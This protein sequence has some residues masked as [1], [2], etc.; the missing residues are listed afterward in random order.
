MYIQATI[1]H[2]LESREAAWKTTVPGDWMRTSGSSD[3]TNTVGAVHDGNEAMSQGEKTA[4]H[5]SGLGRPEPNH[6]IGM[7]R[8]WFAAISMEASEGATMESILS[9]SR[10][11][12]PQISRAN[13]H[14]AS[15][16]SQRSLA[17]HVIYVM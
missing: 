12:L 7:K 17:C 5:R 9:V 15:G 1:T 10:P 13:M 4:F 14:R 16:W 3:G 8:A 6:H 2:L 11:N